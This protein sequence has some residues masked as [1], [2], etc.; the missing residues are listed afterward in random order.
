[1][2][3]NTGTCVYTEYKIYPG[4]GERY[5]TKD[6]KMHLLISK[7]VAELFRRKTKAVKLTWTQAWR[8]FNQKGKVETGTKKRTRRK[9]KTQKAI[10][11]MNLEDINRKKQTTEKEK[12]RDQVAKEIKE[13]KKKKLDIKRRQPKPQAPK[14]PV[15]KQQPKKA[16]AHKGGK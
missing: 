2:V 1:M 7:K 10:A 16:A 11:G 15:A 6:G 9:I 13:R 3:V 4:R 5:V 12:V 8:R 14:K